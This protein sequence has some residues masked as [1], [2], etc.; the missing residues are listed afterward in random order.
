MNRIR[1]LHDGAVI[2]LNFIN[3]KQKPST[4]VLNF[5]RSLPGHKGVKEG[6]AEGDCG[7]CTVVLAEEENGRLKYSAVDSCLMFLPVLH[8][9]QLITVENLAVRNGDD[10]ML[11]PVQQA[12]VNAF[13]SQCGFCTPGIVMSMF[14]LYKNEKNPS[15]ASAEDALTGNLCRCTGYQP[16]LE[17]AL[18]VCNGAPDHF[19]KNEKSVVELLK[20]IKSEQPSVSVVTEKQK[21]FRPSTLSEA[22]SVMKENPDVTIVC[23]AT[24]VALKQTKKFEHIPS[25]LDLSGIDELK[26]IQETEKGFLFGAGAP[27][28]KIRLFCETKLPVLH[29]ILNVFASRQIRNVATLGGNVGSASP[30]GDTLPFLFVATAVVHVQT[31]KAKREIPIRDFITGYRKTA[32]QYEEL[33][34]GIF[35]PKPV[36]GEM[37]KTYKVSKRRDLDISTVSAAFRLKKKGSKIESISIAYGGMSAFTQHA[38]KAEDFLKGKEWIREAVDETLPIIREAFTPLSDA[39]SGAEY[40]SRVA[41]NLLLKFYLETK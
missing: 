21:Y 6:C 32:L 27:L 4:T 9:K 25:M 33:I 18:E 19:S 20:K 5:L 24:D 29:D 12:L 17:A 16:I 10:V 41:A 8:G 14:A 31:E 3:E 28:E 7:A 15:R 11:H 37:I 30:I 1:F 36:V 22:F 2:N 38:E 39:R 40:R 34:T 35:I 23:G 26:N 13:G